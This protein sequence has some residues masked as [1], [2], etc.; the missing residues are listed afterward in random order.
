MVLEYP[1]ENPKVECVGNISL[2][3]QKWQVV[4]PQVVSPTS[5]LDIDLSQEFW[6]KMIQ[7]W[8]ICDGLYTYV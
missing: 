7:N 3:V 4:S 1:N 5:I 2:E 6:E 8:V